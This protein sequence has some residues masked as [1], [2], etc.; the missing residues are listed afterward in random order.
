M[1]TFEIKEDFLLDGKPIKIIS[2]A[3]HYFR[4]TQNQWEDSLYNLKALG[5]NTV[6]TYIPW[7]I[8]EP[9]EG[10][11]DFNGMK[12]V[13]AFVKLAQEMGLYV[14]LR[15][16]AYICAEWEFGGL[17]AWLLKDGLIRLRST[18]KIFMEKVEN[19]YHELLPKLRPLQVTQGG[20]VIMM[21][22]ENEYGSYGMEKEYLLATKKIVESYGIDIP[23]FTSDGSWTEVLDAGSLIDEDVFVAGNFGSQSLKNAAV[24]KDFMTGH[25]KK[26]PIISM[27][28]WDGWFNRWGNDIIKRDPQDLADEVED[29][30]SV[31]SINL[32]MFHGGTNFG[33]YNGCSA[34]G[35]TDLPQVTSYD[36]DAL[37][38]ESGQPTEKY[39][40]VQKAIKKVC[41]D[42]WQAEPRVKELGNLGSFPIDKSVSLFH[43]KDDVV[44]LTY[45]SYPLTMEQASSGYGYLLYD[46]ELK[47]YHHENKFKIIEASDRLKIY[48][49]ESLVATQYQETNGEE[50]ML[51]GN[52]DSDTIHMDI[53][54]ENLGRVNY[55]Y[56]LNNPTQMKGIRGG[57]M[58][59]IHFHQGFKHYPLT[60]SK[61]QL[62]AIDF[63]KEANP[64]HPSFYQSTFNLENVKD[65]YIDCSAYGKGV[66]IVNGINLGRYWDKGPHLSLYCPKEFL[67]VGEN[68]IIIFETEGKHITNVTFSDTPVY[69]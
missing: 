33:F 21:Q 50:L 31:G 68:D 66:V 12:D 10:T 18:D 27:E 22:I 2:G 1:Q 43:T 59:D 9:I 45:S 44:E 65:T 11:F 36:Y 17:P 6:E 8:H 4:M 64:S 35:N 7:N 32:Y 24:L 34:R 63:D 53:L 42:V 49:D 41:P 60:L 61:E 58:Y 15:P 19:Y 55:G 16:S 46:F 30:L 39:Y 23:L 28:Y 25:N 56:K 14:I 29:M 57:V 26:W 54:V 37:L 69:V 67:N 40:L 47:N 52:P 62:A 13:V 5:A 3:I 48:A 20:P 38:N 51:Q